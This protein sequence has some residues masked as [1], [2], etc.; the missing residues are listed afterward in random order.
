MN[1]GGQ[2]IQEDG[3]PFPSQ[4]HPA[5]VTLRTGKPQ[6]R[7]IMGISPP[8]ASL[9]PCPVNDSPVAGNKAKSGGL[10]LRQKQQGCQE[11]RHEITWISMNSQPLF[12]PGDSQPYAVVTSFSDITESKRHFSRLDEAKCKQV[13]LHQGI[14]STLLILKHRLTQKGNRPP[15]QLIKDYGQLPLVKCYPGQ[16][17]QVFMN[18]L[19]NALDALDDA[20]DTAYLSGLPSTKTRDFQDTSKTHPQPSPMIRIHT[21]FVEPNWIIIRIADNGAGINAEVQSRIFDPFFTTKPVGQGTGLGLSISYQ[22]VVDKHGGQLQCH[23]HHPQGTEFVIKL[24]VT[25]SL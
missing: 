11:Q 13:N 25:K 1:W 23:S 22:I 9:L 20:H 4:E 3:S 21:E 5:M 8:E 19:S 15:I 12:N 10:K 2:I 24:P 18:I 17:N 7:V 6:V 16:L 14:D